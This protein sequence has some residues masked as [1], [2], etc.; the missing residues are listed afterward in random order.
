MEERSRG[1]P[2][3]AT[4]LAREIRDC[5][6]TVLMMRAG[7]IGDGLL[8]RMMSAGMVLRAMSVLMSHRGAM[9][10]GLRKA[11]SRKTGEYHRNR[12]NKNNQLAE[13]STH[14]FALT[15]SGD[16]FPQH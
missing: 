15:H 1:A 4:I 16:R 11:R 7:G 8:M 14:R 6:G 13:T 5:T 3:Y 10:T 12:C 2:G 9:H